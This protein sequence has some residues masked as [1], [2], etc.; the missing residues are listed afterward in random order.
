MQIAIRGGD[1]ARL[2]FVF[3]LAADAARGAGFQKPKQFGLERQIHF[4][5]FVEKQGAA[6]GLLD[7][8]G[9]R[10][11]RAGERAFFHAKYFRLDQ[12]LGNR[13][14]VERH[15]LFS[16][17]GIVQRAGDFFLADAG[18][19]EDE[20]VHIR[21]A[22]FF[23][24]LPQGAQRSGIAGEGVFGVQRFAAVQLEPK[25][26]RLHRAGEGG[27]PAFISI[28]F[29]HHIGG[30]IAQGGDDFGGTKLVAG[31]DELPAG[32]GELDADAIPAARGEFAVGDEIDDVGGFGSKHL[33]AGRFEGKN[34]DP[35]WREPFAN[36]FHPLMVKKADSHAMQ[37]NTFALHMQ[38]F[39]LN[40]ELRGLNLAHHKLCS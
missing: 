12:V 9:S 35:Q 1:H 14:A 5:D 19:A 15:E 33:D 39:L 38:L 27:L 25:F 3:R 17:A 26:L 23:H 24:G 31:D 10:F 6:G 16:P 4:P 34:R 37:D 11:E 7:Q 36:G 28:G 29:I 40:E 20:H 30:A 32:A 18:F 13:R 21:R 8:P 22:D 2:G